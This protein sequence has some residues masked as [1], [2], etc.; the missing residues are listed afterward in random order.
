M[1]IRKH[2]GRLFPP[3]EKSI[4]Q[5]LQLGSEEKLLAYVLLQHQHSLADPE[6]TVFRHEVVQVGGNHYFCIIEVT[7]PES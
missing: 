2:L 6:N 3:I 5:R 1:D 4:T 7:E